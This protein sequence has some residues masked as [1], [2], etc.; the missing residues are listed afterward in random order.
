TISLHTYLF[1]YEFNE[2]ILAFTETQIIFFAGLKK[3][4]YFKQLELKP[5]DRK[6]GR[7]ELV[8]I[9]KQRNGLE[10]QFQELW[11]HFRTSKEGKSLGYI[12]KDTWDGKFYQTWLDFIET[13]KGKDDDMELVDVSSYIG[14]VLAVKDGDEQITIKRACAFSATIMDK[15]FR[16]KLEDIIEN[17]VKRKHSELSD[18]IE[19]AITDPAKVNMKLNADLL[20]I[21]YF[22]IVQS[23]GKY[24]LKIS[25]A[26][27]DDILQPDIVIASLGTRYK[28]YCSNIARTYMIN[29]TP[30][31][32]EAYKLIVKLRGMVIAKFL[33]GVEL[34]ALYT[35]CT[36]Y[37]EANKPEWRG[38]FVKNIGFGI[39]IE[40]RDSD[41]VINAKS[42]YKALNGM[43]FNLSIGLQGIPIAGGKGKGKVFAVSVADTVLIQQGEITVLTDRCA[44]K[45]N[46][47]V[48]SLE[49]EEDKESTKKKS[50]RSHTTSAGDYEAPVGRQ[51]RS[52]VLNSRTRGEDKKKLSDDAGIRQKQAELLQ[53][54]NANARRRILEGQDDESEK[55]LDIRQYTAYNRLSEI[56][57]NKSALSQQRIYVDHK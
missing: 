31:Q 44:L 16:G 10:G 12:K 8:F 56:P 20:E 43:T 39:G 21:C 23:G 27:N 34:S 37:L 26:S 1:D 19:K 3:L 35:L 30:D 54:I 47:I 15:F 50:S 11:T 2:S 36:D 5:E 41:T 42:H 46:D 17:E 13:K 18:D 24:D 9:E 51:T 4:A 38:Y 22:P 29:P 25:A 52:N 49:D 45:Y 7:P 53:I 6:E 57:L 40:F 48:Y 14:R 33:P 55:R 28:S 32:T